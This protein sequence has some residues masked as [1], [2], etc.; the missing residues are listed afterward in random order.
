[1]DGNYAIYL[2]KSRSDDANATIEET[3][4]R[5]E[6]LLLEV[7]KKMELN[8]V[9][10]YREIVSGE[11]IA[12]RPE[13]QK[14]LNAVNQELYDG[15]LVVEIE[16]LAR[17][18]SIDQGI[19]S[20]SFQLSDT[21]IITPNKIID[22]NNEFDAESLE[23]G[24]FMS[25]REYKTINRR[26]QRGRLASVK[27]GKYVGNHAP[28]GYERKKLEHGKGFT[29]ISVLEQAEVVK[30]IFDLYTKGEQQ[31]NDTYRRLGISLIVRKLNNLKIKP[32]KGDA[33]VLASVR[34]ILIN[35]V[36]IGKV[37]W[38]WRPSIKKMVNGK[39][40]KARPRSNNVILVD[41]LHEGLIAPDTFNLA[42]KI[43][44]SNPA[45]PVSS[46]NTLKNP[47]AGIVFCGKCGRAMIR[48]PYSDKTK[49]DTLMCP[50]PHCTNVSV[51]L[52]SVEQEIIHVL[53]SW[54]NKF[55]INLHSEI[56]DENTNEINIIKNRIKR[57]DLELKDAQTQ[58]NS[59]YDS[60]EKGIYNADVFLERSK[61]I[62]SRIE[63]LKSDNKVLENNLQ[64]LSSRILNGKLIIPKIEYLLEVY[65]EMP[66]AQ[67][68]N[69]LLK[70]VIKKVSYTK[71]QSGR[72]NGTPDDFT[73]EVELIMY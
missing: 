55:K 7:A 62:T 26:L 40:V 59:I 37:R 70:E 41:G 49:Y 22:P 18:N 4:S 65:N 16:R 72:W 66:N 17:G 54:I 50:A 3:L 24:L 44:K 9:K 52:D 67:A 58:M 36:Y 60:Y 42:Q 15:V 71:E 34:D 23:F 35:P 11:S 13:M 25:R 30:M 6:K 61:V 1:M 51:K 63:T 64:K 43:I 46:R 27:E 47:L 45:R 2:R 32:Q 29:L 31:D 73:L 19:I 68:K 57:N 20:Q 56:D 10:I 5:H 28:Y 8:I 48:R 69:D 38:N 12:D 53:E 39:L 33:W 21:K 14:L